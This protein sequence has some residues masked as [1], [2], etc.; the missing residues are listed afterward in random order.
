MPQALDQEPL[1]T[2]KRR[3]KASVCGGCTRRERVRAGLYLRSVIMKS[4]I[5]TQLLLACLAIMI[6]SARLNAQLLDPDSTFG[7]NGTTTLDLQSWQVLT[8]EELAT[9]V[10]VQSTGRIILGGYI[11]KHYALIGLLPT[12]QLDTQFGD[13]GIVRLLD[14]ARC[15]DVIVL[16][17]DRILSCGY[18]NGGTNFPAQY[19]AIVARHLSDG[20]PDSS[21]ND[22][23]FVLLPSVHN[24]DGLYGLS[25]QADG[26]ILATGW[27]DY[28]G[29]GYVEMLAARLLP[30]GTLDASFGANGMVGAT[31]S[32]GE[33]VGHGI[34]QVP[35]GSIVFGGSSSYFL[36]RIAMICRVLGDGTFDPTFG[37]GG[38]AVTAAGFYE[39]YGFELAVQP[40]GRSVLGGYRLSP[41]IVAAFR[42]DQ[43]GLLDPTFSVDGIATGGAFANWL[44]YASGSMVALDNGGFIAVGES[45]GPFRLVHFTSNGAVEATA[46]TFFPEPAAAWGACLQ[47]DGKLLVCGRTHN[48]FSGDELAIA[49]YGAGSPLSSAETTSSLHSISLYPNPVTERMVVQCAW[50]GTLRLMVH[51]VMGRVI[52]EQISKNGSNSVFD[53]ST[54]APGMYCLTALNGELQ[55][56]RNFVKE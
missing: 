1:A 55:Q 37:T 50:S 27:R 39:H 29:D 2:G 46:T 3:R 30:N 15:Q 41:P 48:I 33:C 6:L 7:L 20:S 51:D 54:L 23:G 25:L 49:R 8:G 32:A 19:R 10:D 5:T 47:P 22:S 24:H 21:F 34:V 40:D 35:D 9:S 44:D 11:G 43:S 14:D 56:T 17:D 53:L 26:R 52:Q 42:F 31:L 45:E 38:I 36:D 4:S 13:S 16:D 28:D 12:G 18:G